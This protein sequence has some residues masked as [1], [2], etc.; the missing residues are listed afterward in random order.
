MRNDSPNLTST[1]SLRE[2]IQ[3][4]F[5]ESKRRFG[6]RRVRVELMKMGWKVSKMLV[7]KLMDQMNLKSKVRIRR[8]YSSYKGKTSHIAET[9]SNASSKP[10]RRTPSGSAT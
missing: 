5:T 9:Y 2:D 10:M 3:T 4:I 1:R 7:W 8:K 6:Y